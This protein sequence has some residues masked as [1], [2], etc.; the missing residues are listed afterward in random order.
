MKEHHWNEL[1]NYALSEQYKKYYAY[2]EERFKNDELKSLLKQQKV[3]DSKHY[4]F[5]A[6]IT[7]SSFSLSDDPSVWNGTTMSFLPN[8]NPNSYNPIMVLR[9]YNSTYEPYH[10]HLNDKDYFICGTDYQGIT[11]VNLTDKEIKSYIEAFRYEKGA[12]YCII[13]ILGYD[14]D[15]KILTVAGCYWG[16]PYTKREYRFDIEDPVL[17]EDCLIEEWPDDED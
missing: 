12:C 13:E 8:P 11:V 6:D 4:K 1:E 2:M 14:E 17:C 15:D 16:F 3:L 10:V 7:I 5:P 9:N